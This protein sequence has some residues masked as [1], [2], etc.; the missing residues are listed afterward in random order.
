M[1]VKWV[2]DYRSAC[3]EPLRQ[4][5]GRKKSMDASSKI[6]TIKSIENT[7]ADTSAGIK[8]YSRVIG[9]P[10]ATYMY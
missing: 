8:K 5:K 6:Q 9:F 7:S 1:I 2:I 3:P 4:K 10:K